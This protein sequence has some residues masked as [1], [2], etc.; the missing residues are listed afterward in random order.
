MHFVQLIFVFED[1]LE[2]ARTVPKEAW[3]AE[4]DPA[5]LAQML[6]NSGKAVRD[7]VEQSGARPRHEPSL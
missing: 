4:N 7:V 2:F 3:V 1:A 6:N 5:R